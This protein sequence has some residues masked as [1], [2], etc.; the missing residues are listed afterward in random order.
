MAA[1]DSGEIIRSNRNHQGEAGE[2]NFDHV[3]ADCVSCRR[4]SRMPN[5]SLKAEAFRP[6][7]RQR[8]RQSPCGR[9]QDL[10]GLRLSYFPACVPD[11][12]PERTGEELVS[13]SFSSFSRLSTP[14]RA[15]SWRRI[16]SWQDDHHRLESSGKFLHHQR[17]RLRCRD[18]ARFQGGGRNVKAEA[19][20]RHDAENRRREEYR[21]RRAQDAKWR[22]ETLVDEGAHRAGCRRELKVHPRRKER[23]KSA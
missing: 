11:Q 22:L 12:G 20:P 23:E 1:P 5:V 4:P 13:I 18:V 9:R 10:D 3:F 14:S 2:R 16:R 6:S 7:S 8:M 15:A 21:R 19:S 17:Q